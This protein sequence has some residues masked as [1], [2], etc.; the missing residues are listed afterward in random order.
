M[1]LP[2]YS[3]PPTPTLTLHCQPHPLI[4]TRPPTITHPCPPLPPPATHIQPHTLIAS[5]T[6]SQSITT[7]IHT[8]RLPPHGA[9]MHW[10]RDDAAGCWHSAH[11]CP[12]IQFPYP[13][14]MYL[15]RYG[16]AVHWTRDDAAG[17]WHST[18]DWP[19][20]SADSLAPPLP[21]PSTSAAAPC[22][23]QIGLAMNGVR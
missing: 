23:A 11:S 14:I 2:I 12:P 21:C 9:P 8:P 17:C 4:P 20:G 18:T 13:T 19:P 6:Q 3:H 10:T 1:H 7:P 15:F 22:P 16:A 5:P